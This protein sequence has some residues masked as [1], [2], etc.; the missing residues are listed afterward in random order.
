MVG[1]GL[2]TI[3]DGAAHGA[4]N[5]KDVTGPV[6]LVSV[7]GEASRSGIGYILSLA[8]FI[9]V[10]LAV[11]NLIPI[12]ALDGG[13]LV[14]VALEAIIRRPAPRIA[15]QTLNAL[16]IFLILLLMVVVTYNDVA[17]LIA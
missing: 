14:I 6:G 12:P 13:R 17:R 5:L 10:N 16:G 1:Q 2:W 15:M 9:S 3:I 7:V 4:P 11:I 8:A